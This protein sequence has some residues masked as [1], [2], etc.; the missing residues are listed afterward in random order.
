MKECLRSDR[1]LFDPTLSAS[2][3]PLRRTFFPLGFPLDLE[4]NS[5]HVIQAAE[6]GWDHF[7]KA[8]DCA[9]A[10]LSVGVTNSDSMPTE[11]R[12]SFR[13]REHLMSVIADPENFLVCDFISAFAFGWVTRAV[14]ADHPFLRYRFLTAAAHMLIQ[15][16]ALA[17]VHGAL[18]SRHGMGILLCGESF[19]GKSTL[20]Y[21]CARAGWVYVSDDAS[22]LL[23]ER[24]DRYAIGDPYAIRFREDARDL[25]P[26]LSD[27]M[28]VVRPNGKI[29]IEIPTRELAVATANGCSV[30]HVIFLNRKQGRATE[31]CRFPK[32]DAFAALSSYASFGT[33]HVRTAQEHCYRRL[34]TADIW[35]LTYGHFSDAV[36]RL[37]RLVSAGG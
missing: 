13:S 26:E 4:T 24:N 14:A 3:L 8:Y 35:E 10:R 15:Q 36:E 5:L 20:A 19:A 28:P 29:A 25:F 31:L 23:R 16:S 18:V 27:L 22:H 9:P 2:D 30:E 12:S 11:P 1:V 7:A 37:D 17:P 33:Q 6:E 21:A 34:L 32:D